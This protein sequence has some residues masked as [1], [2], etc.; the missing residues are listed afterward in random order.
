[1]KILIIS[2]I[3]SLIKYAQEIDDEDMVNCLNDVLEDML[4]EMDIQ[5]N[6]KSDVSPADFVGIIGDVKPELPVGTVA[7]PPRFY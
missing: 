6:K 7:L 3:S 4:F 1:M 5:E 2:K